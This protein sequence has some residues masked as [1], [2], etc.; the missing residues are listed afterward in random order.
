MEEMEHN[1]KAVTDE[2]QDVK[3]E[4]SVFR[5]KAHRLN[6]ELNHVLGNREAR[7]IDVDALCMENRQVGRRSRS[8]VHRAA[9][10]VRSTSSYSS[11]WCFT[12]CKHIF[13][14]KSYFSGEYIYILHKFNISIKALKEKT[15][16]LYCDSS[17]IDCFLFFN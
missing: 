11:F 8:A 12:G 3:S 17:P 9:A 13:V 16:S 14:E 1:L 10:N 5:E 7:I 6:V 4:R 15:F 2:L